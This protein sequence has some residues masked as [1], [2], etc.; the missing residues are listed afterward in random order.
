MAE[1][2]SKIEAHAKARF[3]KEHA[4]YQATLAQ[5]EEKAKASG[6]NPAA[7]PLSHPLRGRRPKI[8]SA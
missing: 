8:R 6:K 1:A 4:E 3:T 5:R 7:Q 2:K